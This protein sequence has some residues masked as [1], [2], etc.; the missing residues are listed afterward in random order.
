MKKRLHGFT[1]VELIVV[2]AIIGVLAAI[3]VPTM[4]GYVKKA[5]ITSLNSTAKSLNNAVATAITTLDTTGIYVADTDTDYQPTGDLNHEIKQ[6]FKNIE[7]LEQAHYKI[8]NC[9][10]VGTW[11]KKGGY[12][13]AYP[14]PTSI[15]NAQTEPV[16]P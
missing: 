6:Y 11:V 1:L 15:D 9:Q 12:Y 13:G 7:T 3:L 4:L 2:I 14:S 10:C 8:K 5:K 16:L